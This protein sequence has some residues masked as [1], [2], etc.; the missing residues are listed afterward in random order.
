MPSLRDLQLDFMESLLAEP[1]RSAGLTDPRLGLYRWN[2]RANFLGSLE[3]TFPVL[4]RLVGPQYF[5]QTALA[6][7]LS[8]PSRSGDL[9]DAGRGFPEFLES[10]HAEGEYRYL[11]DVAHFEWLCQE[12]L[13]AAEHAPLDLAR[14]RKLPPDVYGELE[15]VLHPALMLYES[16]FPVLRIWQENSLPGREPDPIDLDCGGDRLAIVS[17]RHVL[18]FHPLGEGE[19]RFLDALRGAAAFSAALEA[20]DAAAPGFDA[21]AALQRFVAA[22]MIVDFLKPPRSPPACPSPP[23]F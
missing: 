2:V 20:A 1:L 19:H 8:N 18:E 22:H 9:K 3:S 7:H 13:L 12:S 10:A 15:F 16:R 14:L 6:F 23:N 17:R 4:M 11:G 21:G 5:E